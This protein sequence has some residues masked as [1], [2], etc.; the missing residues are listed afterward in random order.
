M[1]LKTTKE[2]NFTFW[3]SRT[4]RRALFIGYNVGWV[5]AVKKKVIKALIPQCTPKC[6]LQGSDLLRDFFPLLFPS[7]LF[8]ICVDAFDFSYLC[9]CILCQRHLSFCMFTFVSSVLNLLHSYWRLMPLSSMSLFF[10]S[11]FLDTLILRKKSMI[12]FLCTSSIPT[13]D[14]VYGFQER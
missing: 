8:C 11:S 2:L 10:C 13:P 6:E 4:S 5:W 3:A 12:S 7:R 1:Q 14:L 9:V